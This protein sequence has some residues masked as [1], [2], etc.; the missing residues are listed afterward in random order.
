MDR[1]YS[2]HMSGDK[3]KFLSWKLVEKGNVTFGNNAPGK[4]A[5]KGVVS[6]A[7]D[8]GKSK[9]VFLVSKA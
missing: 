8:K 6:L 1:G 3:S 4:I 7:N 5:S 2:I 9:D